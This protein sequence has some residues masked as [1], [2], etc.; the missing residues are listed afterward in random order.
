KTLG[1]KFFV[2]PGSF[3][4]GTEAIKQI[5]FANTGIDI[6]NARLEDGSGLSRNNRISATKMAEMLRYIWKHENELKL[7][8]IMPKSGE[9]GTLKYR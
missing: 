4:N 1:A 8:A 7:I 5:I 2:Q 9:S 6:R 3:T